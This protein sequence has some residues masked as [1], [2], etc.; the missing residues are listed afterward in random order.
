M[1][2]NS[3]IKKIRTQKM[4]QIWN[5]LLLGQIVKTIKNSKTCF[6]S[7]KHGYSAKT[8][9][10]CMQ[11]WLVNHSLTS[12]LQSRDF[13]WRFLAQSNLY[14]LFCPSV[15]PYGFPKLQFVLWARNMNTLFQFLSLI[16]FLNR[17]PGKVK[18]YH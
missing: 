11:W 16:L 8:N 6:Y 7:Y 17:V 10:L 18:V 13:I 15:R 4:A 5:Y 12:Y 14:R 1:K 9:V 3:F 2:K